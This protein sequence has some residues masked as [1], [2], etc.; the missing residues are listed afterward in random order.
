MIRVHPAGAILFGIAFLFA[1]SSE[2]LA[3][4]IGLLWHELGH[5]AAMRL[6]GVRNCKVELTPFGAMAD[7]DVFEGLNACQQAFCAVAGVLASACG[8]AL[9]RLGT[10]VF[11]VALRNVHASLLIVNCLPAWPLDGAR[12]LLAFARMAGFEYV[13]RRLFAML[14]ILLGAG[15]V[16]LG[17]WS[18]WL[19]MTNLSLLLGGPY[20]CYAARQGEISRRVRYMHKN[21]EKLKKA[22]LLPAAAYVCDE[23]S[24]VAASGALLGKTDDSRYLLLLTL[25]DTGK[26]LRVRTEKEMMENI[27]RS[28]A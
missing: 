11:V 24:E 10:G 13:A 1:P 8:M 4:V 26:L 20:L 27:V 15:M 17:L 3:V 6:C 18:V 7:A 19:G 28:K 12:M 14:T 2:V 25:D 22:C 21:N 16:L 23:C 9:C 5:L